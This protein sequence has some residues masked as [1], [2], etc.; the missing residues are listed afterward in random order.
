[1][2]FVVRHHIT[3]RSGKKFDRAMYYRREWRRSASA[4]GNNLLEETGK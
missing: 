3:K 4:Y 2:K 1:M